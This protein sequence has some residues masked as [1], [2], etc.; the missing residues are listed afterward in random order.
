[1]ELPK[2]YG[3]CAESSLGPNK[4][5]GFHDSIERKCHIIASGAVLQSFSAGVGAQSI[6]SMTLTWQ[7]RESCLPLMAALGLT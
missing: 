2:R 1:M 3:R 4:S 7:Q 6:L 5:V